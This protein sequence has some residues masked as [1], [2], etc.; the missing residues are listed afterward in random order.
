[1][2]EL[3]LDSGKVMGYFRKNSPCHDTVEGTS[4]AQ[5]I[6][7]LACAVHLLEEAS[8]NLKKLCQYYHLPFTCICI[9]Q[10]SILRT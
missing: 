2:Q 10:F 3:T 7:R 6:S 8:C 9:S 4:P 5:K 1:M